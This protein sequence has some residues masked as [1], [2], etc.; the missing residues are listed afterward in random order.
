ME[1][2]KLIIFSSRG[3]TIHLRL[4]RAAGVIDRVRD[5]ALGLDRD[6]V[7]LLPVVAVTIHRKLQVELSLRPLPP[8]GLP[9]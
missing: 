4:E 3:G 2:L 6:L 1:Q 8:G 9:K 5:L 7:H